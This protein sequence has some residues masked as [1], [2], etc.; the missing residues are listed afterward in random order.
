MVLNPQ[1]REAVTLHSRTEHGAARVMPQELHLRSR[2]SAFDAH[3]G[4][5]C[6]GLLAL[7]DAAVNRNSCSTFTLTQTPTPTSTP[8]LTLTSFVTC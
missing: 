6:R 8:T 2:M 7:A 1:H 4:R 3:M 5:I